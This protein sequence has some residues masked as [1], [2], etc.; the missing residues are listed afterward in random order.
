MVLQA[1]YICVSI[2]E[3]EVH[4]TQHMTIPSSFVIARRRSLPMRRRTQPWRIFW[5]VITRIARITK[6]NNRNTIVSI[7]GLDFTGSSAERLRS[8]VFRKSKNLGAAS[9][10]LKALVTL[11][12][13]DIDVVPFCLSGSAWHR[14][15]NKTS[16]QAYEDWH[17]E[18]VRI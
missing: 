18:D 15:P 16:L 7:T 13:F 10:A 8:R 2:R 9:L 1:F 4:P 14:R 12:I 5:N 11:A 17:K 6:Q 3:G